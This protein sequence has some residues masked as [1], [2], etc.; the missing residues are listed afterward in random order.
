METSIARIKK[1]IETIQKF[2]STPGQGCTR[3]SYSI[4]DKKAKNYLIDEMISL[5]M[6]VKIDGVGNLRGMY[7]GEYENLPIILVG[8]H[9]DTVKHGGSFDGITGV[10][11]A[12][13]VIRV[14]KENNIKTKH[15]IGLIGFAEEEGS[16]FGA[17]TL[18]SKVI[19]GKIPSSELKNI[20]NFEGKSYYEVL[21]EYGLNPE[22]IDN[23]RLDK[24]DILGMLELHIEQSIVLDKNN[25]SIGIV[26]GIAG[27]RTYGV[28]IIGESNHAGATPMNMR[29]DALIAASEI[30]SH[31]ND[32]VK[33]NGLDTTVATVGKIEC[34][35]NVSN[36]IAEKVYFTIDIRD[37]D[38]HA[39]DRVLKE[40]I[41]YSNKIS[42]KYGVE[43]NVRRITS[44]KGTTTCE[45]IINIIE[46]VVKSRGYS[47]CKMLSG[48][49]HDSAVMA[50]ITDVGMI[51]VPSKDGKSHVPE[52][53]TSF[54]DIK[55]GSDV[56]LETLIKLDK[57]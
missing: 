5:G 2:S 15:T 29:K 16:N 20:K 47:Y 33:E 3:F 39:M 55:R 17:T 37:L 35:P 22:N 13:E 40:V 23:E 27:T 36:V 30:I 45:K 42:D 44:F 50:E 57:I 4:E 48:A 41:N 14:L 52:E 7:K 1:D 26:K 32:I 28:E 51:F 31:V 53:Y 8:S 24:K 11:A 38:D 10:V 9:M 43:C 18:G 6:D 12:L 56:L 34:H 19:T 46:D 49:V 54:E 25:L 21:E